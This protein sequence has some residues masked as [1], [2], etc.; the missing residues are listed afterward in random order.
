M[1]F[2]FIDAMLV[3]P[4]SFNCRPCKCVSK[5]NRKCHKLFALFLVNIWIAQSSYS[6]SGLSLLYSMP[7][8]SSL[9]Y[10]HYF[11]HLHRCIIFLMI[12]RTVLYPS[13]TALRE[14]RDASATETGRLLRDFYNTLCSGHTTR[15]LRDSFATD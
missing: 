9:P 14:R 15:L 13:H 4:V 11:H 6:S 12:F 7:L 10:L 5:S 8:F 3:M 1:R 2:R